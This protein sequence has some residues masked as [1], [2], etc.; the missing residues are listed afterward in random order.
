MSP[1]ARIVFTITFV[2]I[3]GLVTG[4]T[5]VRDIPATPTLTPTS[6]PT[7]TPTNTPTNTPTPSITPTWTPTVTDTP[8]P[9]WTPTVTDTPTP[10]W[11][12]TVTDTPTPTPTPSNTP[13]ITP[14]PW[15]YMYVQSSALQL[16]AILGEDTPSDFAS[17]GDA[18]V[19]YEAR[20]MDGKYWFLVMN[21]KSGKMGWA[22][23]TYL[24][25]EP[26]GDVPTATRP[27]TMPAPTRRPTLPANLLPLTTATSVVAF[28]ESVTN[29]ETGETGAS[30]QEVM[31]TEP[32]ATTGR[33]PFVI[34][35][36]VFVIV[37][38]IVFGGLR[39]AE[40]RNQIA[41]WVVSEVLVSI[42]L[43]YFYSSIK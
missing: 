12:P 19:L 28:Q 29:N 26:P 5:A 7:Y 20:L 22:S 9:T 36:F 35:L 11:T 23:D 43:Y 15:L 37:A 14:T 13:T 42:I 38:V 31:G 32:R 2:A 27:A 40:V 18:L 8:T 4:C 17:Y 16:A 1:F 3:F 6:T 24:S 41:I 10:T 34:T 21:P 30:M 39:E 33:P 25:L